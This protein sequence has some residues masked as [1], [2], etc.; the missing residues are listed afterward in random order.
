VA[1]DILDLPR[2][3]SFFMQA[4]LFNIIYG[5]LPF[6]LRRREKYLMAL[7]HQGAPPLQNY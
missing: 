1:Q 6:F 4:N 5:M 2:L 3:S 7:K